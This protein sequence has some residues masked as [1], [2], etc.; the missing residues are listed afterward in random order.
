MCLTGC[1]PGTQYPG[2]LQLWRLRECLLP[3]LL[4]FVWRCQNVFYLLTN[5]LFL[6]QRMSVDYYLP[7]SVVSLLQKRIWRHFGICTVSDVQFCGCFSCQR[8]VCECIL[9][10]TNCHLNN[11]DSVFFNLFCLCIIKPE[12][13]SAIHRHLKKVMSVR[14]FLFISWEPFILS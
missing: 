14:Y 11:I 1:E 13:S 6:V 9:L 10:W 12:K 3:I 8:L 4:A 5:T 2:W 7:T